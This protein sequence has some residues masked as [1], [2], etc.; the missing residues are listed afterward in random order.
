MPINN[1]CFRRNLRGRDRGCRYPND[2]VYKRLDSDTRDH[3]KYVPMIN[4][5]P[6][7]PPG[8]GRQA[9]AVDYFVQLLG[10]RR[11]HMEL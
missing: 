7:W 8:S 11:A 5:V 6:C 1:D 2:G 9:S 10:R 3:V 4:R